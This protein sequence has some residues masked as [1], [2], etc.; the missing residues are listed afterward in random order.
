MVNIGIIGLGKL[1]KTHAENIMYK[2]P[3]ANLIAACARRK[4]VIND[5][6][7]KHSIKY[8]YND[9]N[10]MLKNKEIDAI[11]IVTSVNVHADMV[12]KSS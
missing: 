11:V 5:F 2:I 7:A 3:N 8:T 4:S 9:F 10:E 12:I 1:G 6:K